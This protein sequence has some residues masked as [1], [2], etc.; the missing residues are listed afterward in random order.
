[1]SEKMRARLESLPLAEIRAIAKENGLKRI[2]ATRKSDLIEALLALLEHNETASPEE[3]PEQ[4]KAEPPAGSHTAA[5][6]N[7]VHTEMLKA[8][9]R[10]ES[11]LGYRKVPA[12]EEKAVRFCSQAGR[13]EMEAPR[14]VYEIKPRSPMEQRLWEEE[15]FGWEEDRSREQFRRRE[16]NLI[17]EG[18]RRSGSSRYESLREEMSRGE[19]SKEQY[20]EEVRGLEIA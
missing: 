13:R 5:L 19:V 3:K 6:T 18:Q 14:P 12:E 9:S 4:V 20:R 16:E 11:L 1:M 15:K 8:E 10:T 7:P 2:T 17:R